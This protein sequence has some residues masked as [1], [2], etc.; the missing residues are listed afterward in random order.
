MQSKAELWKAIPGWEG[1]YEASTLGHIRS[2]DHAIVDTLGRLQH[3]TG[4]HLRSHLRRGRRAITLCAKNQ[5]FQYSIS[6]LMA[7]TFLPNPLQRPIVDHIDRNPLND[8]LSNLRWASH[9]Q[10]Q[11]NRSPKKGKFKGVYHSHSKKHPWWAR[12]QVGRRPIHLGHFSTAED[13]A[14]A[15]NHAAI[16]YHGEF[17]CLNSLPKANT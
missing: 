2:V 15:Y 17:A 16:K 7:A 4:K 14:T 5:L 8:K 3:C 11:Q 1:Y 13:A 10:S 6:R 9:S 12:I